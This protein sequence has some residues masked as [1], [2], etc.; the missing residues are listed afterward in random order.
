MHEITS[1]SCRLITV[2][3]L[4]NL[5]Q[6]S[7]I[8]IGQIL[9]CLRECTQVADGEMRFGLKMK[10]RKDHWMRHRLG[11]SRNLSWRSRRRMYKEDRQMETLGTLVCMF[12][13]QRKMI[14]R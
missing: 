10:M 8:Q 2:N 7:S 4:R 5:I 14:G 12:E 11:D 1:K 3:N 9:N 13:H 6:L